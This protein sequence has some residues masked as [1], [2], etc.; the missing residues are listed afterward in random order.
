MQYAIFPMKNVRITKRYD[1]NHYAW[2]IA[3]Q[4][5]DAEYWRAPCT[6]KVLR[7]LSQNE[8]S[9]T[10]L[11]GTCDSNGN[12]SSVMCADGVQ[13]VLTFACT[14][15]DSLNRFGLAEGKIYQSGE[16]CYQEGNFGNSSGNHVHMEVGLDWIYSKEWIGEEPNRQYV[17]LNPSNV[18]E[19][20]FFILK[21]WNVLYGLNGYSFPVTAVRNS[22]SSP[23]PEKIQILLTNSD[24]RLRNNVVNGDIKTT[25][26]NGSTFDVIGLYSWKAQDGYR[27]GYGS[28]NGIDGYFQ[29]DPYV[30]NPIGS[31]PDDSYKMIITQIGANLRNTIRGEVSLT[32]PVNESI[33][34]DTF[35]DGKQLDGYQW[36][37]GHYKNIYGYFQYD[38]NNMFPTND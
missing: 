17:L 32:V 23:I 9:N 12:K 8:G 37:F 13:R 4:G 24:A 28:W 27:W 30:M 10:V 18:I 11:F 5:T 15:I 20:T 38:P 25:I 14:H 7:I 34:I 29:Y 2:D 31:S 26:P 6:I 36:C 35:I 21:N 22:D 3:G 1:S 33:I 19:K 16:V